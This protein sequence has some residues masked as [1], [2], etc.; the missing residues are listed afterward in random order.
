MNYR[1]GA[2]ADVSDENGLIANDRPSRD[3]QRHISNFFTQNETKLSFT[4]ML[5]SVVN[6]RYL[7][8][9]T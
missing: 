6:F 1:S 7:C 3:A 4:Q 5:K 8:R 9:P 2:D